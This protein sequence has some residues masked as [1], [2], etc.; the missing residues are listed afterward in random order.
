VG[1][2]FTVVRRL[3]A[4]KIDLQVNSPSATWRNACES[5]HLFPDCHG[6]TH[7]IPHM[8]EPMRVTITNTLSLV[9]FI[10]SVPVFADTLVVGSVYFDSLQTLNEVIKLSAQHDNEGIAKLI[11]NGHVKNQTE[12][13]MNITVLTS[14]SR[15]EDPAEF[16]FLNDPTTYWTVMKNVTTLSRSIP[17]STPVPTPAR[18]PEATP[19]PTE[20][21][22]LTSKQYKRKTP[23]DDDN[24]QRIWHKVDGKWKWYFA[25]KHHV[26]VKK[27][28]PPDAAPVVKP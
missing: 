6:E 12:A 14:G 11:G 21:P 16:R 5:G 28:L 25:N 19:P 15:P 8:I 26:L 7:G 27:A 24:G 17:S 20:S 1:S 3:S 13:E 10:T 18:T 22:T 23:F 4:H 9:L 2:F